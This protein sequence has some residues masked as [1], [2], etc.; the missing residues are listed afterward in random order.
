MVPITPDLAIVPLI[1]HS[2]LIDITLSSTAVSVLV[3]TSSKSSILLLSLVSFNTWVIANIPIIT[4][5]ISIPDKRVELP[6]VNLASP[7]IGS[8]PTVASHSPNKPDISVLSTLP[9]SSAVNTDNPIKDIA[10]NSEGPN[11]KAAV[12]SCGLIKNI[13]IAAAIPPN[14][15]QNSEILN[16]LI[17]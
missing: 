12:A 3:A 1:S 8:I 10:N 11:F 17:G 9:S 6:Q 7:P 4:G 14:A 15:E 16:A 2:S 13:A 5:I